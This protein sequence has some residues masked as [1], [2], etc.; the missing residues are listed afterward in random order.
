MNDRAEKTKYKTAVVY[1]RTGSSDQADMG[2]GLE[3]QQRICEDSAR[4]RGLHVTRIYADA[5]VSGVGRP[6]TKLGPDAE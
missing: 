4:K 2:N 6:T 1:M 5:G 3:S